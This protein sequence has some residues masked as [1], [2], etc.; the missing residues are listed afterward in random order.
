VKLLID[1][2]V[3]GGAREAIAAA[4]HDAIWAADWPEDPGDEE[5]LARAYSDGRTLVTLDKDFGELAIVRGSPHRGI[6]RLCHLRST[7]QAQVCLHV[8]ALHGVELSAGAIITAEPLRI[9]IRPPE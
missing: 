6:L 3:W 2:C 1:T 9:R 4:G 7:Q 8:L 5:I